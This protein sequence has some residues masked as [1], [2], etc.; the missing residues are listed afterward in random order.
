MAAY[1]YADTE[2][3]LSDIAGIIGAYPETEARLIPLYERVEQMQRKLVANDNVRD[4][5]RSRLRQTAA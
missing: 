1:T 4:R 2:R 3:W 5:I